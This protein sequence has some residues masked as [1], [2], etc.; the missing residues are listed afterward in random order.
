MRT[1]NVIFTV[2]I[3]FGV[4]Y[5]H[6][7]ISLAEQSRDLATLRVMGF[8]HGEVTTILLGELAILTAMAVPLGCAF[9]YLLAWSLV[10]V[11][12][13]EMYRI[14]LVIQPT[15]FGFAIV[16]VVISAFVSGLVMLRKIRALDLVGVL[17]ARE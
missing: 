1:F 17:K 10:W 15:T 13:T 4:I 11:M 7:R 9:G 3:A 2:V 8:T 14:P 12:E 6:A 5:N 16:V